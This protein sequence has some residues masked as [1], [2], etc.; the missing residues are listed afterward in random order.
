[1]KCSSGAECK[2]SRTCACLRMWLKDLIDLMMKFMQ[3]KLMRKW[4]TLNK[5][6]QH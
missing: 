1:M 5:K 4:V 3:T 2:E 6:V